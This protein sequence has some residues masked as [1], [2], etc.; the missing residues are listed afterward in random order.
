MTDIRRTAYPR[1]NPHLTTRELEE[2]YQPTQAELHFINVNTKGTPQRL[3]LLLLLKS[4][5]HLGYLPA[6][7]LVPDKIRAYLCQ[8]LELPI[9]TIPEGPERSLQRYRQL[10]RTFLDV[11]PYTQGGQS[12]VASAIRLAAHTMSDPADLINVAMEQL[13]HQRYELPAF[14]LLDRQV[15]HIRHQVHEELYTLVTA[16][17]SE[18]Q[19]QI[20]EQ[21]LAV[22]PEQRLTDFTRFKEAPGTATLKAIRHWEERLAWLDLFPNAQQLLAA[23][24]NT[25]IK[26]FAAQAHALEVSDMHDIQ[27]MSRRHTLLLCL[28]YQAQVQTRDQL[29]L[30]VLKRMRHIHANAKHR[31]RTLQDQ[32]RT[33]TEMMI[34]ALAQIAQQATETAIDAELGHQTRQILSQFGGPE[35]L[36]QHYQLVSAYHDNNYLPLLWSHFR[37]H[38]AVLFRLLSRLELRTTTQEQSLMSA[39][40]FIQHHQ[41]ARKDALPDEISIAFASQRWQTLI[42]TQRNG[43][44]LLQRRALEACVFSYL[45]DGL[46]S[47]DLF[48][49]G[50]EEYADYRTQLLDWHV[51]QQRLDAYCRGLELPNT[52]GAFIQQLR[53]QLTQA[54]Q[55]LDASMPDHAELTLD[56]DGSP[57]LRRGG[58]QSIPPGM[59]EVEALVQ[60]RMPERALLDILKRVQYWVDFTRHFGPPSGADPK[61]KDAISRYLITVF[62]YGCNLGPAQTAR[63]TR[64]LVTLR[65]LKRISD[66]HIST[67]ALEAALRDIINEY[68]RFRLPFFWGAGRAAV[69]DG[70]H[71]ELRKNNLLGEHHIRY[72]SYGGIAYHHISDT[73][74][75][76]F[77]HFI[78]CGV[79]EAVYILDGLLKNE[80]DLQPDTLHADTHGQSEP[81]F[82]LAYLL[83]IQLL[84]RIRQW[85]NLTF[86]RPDKNV[87]YQHIDALFTQ[88]IDWDLIERH[89]P[90]LLQVVLSIQAGTVLPSMLL[91]KLSSYSRQ[92]KLY[93]A[94]REL[95]R[96]VRTLFLV[97]YIS[98]ATLRQG[99]HAATTKIEAYHN[100][101]DWITFG[102]DGVL[103]PR[104]PSEQE[105][106]IKYTD[107]VANAVMLQNVADM[108]DVLHQLAQEGYTIT[109]A[110]VARFSP[111][112]TGNIK[113]F[114]DYVLDM[115]S[116]PDPLQPDKIFWTS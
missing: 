115:D 21:M 77:S 38:R 37:S 109:S 11:K 15:N 3:T 81:V 36:T 54:T 114:G 35:M 53:E 96:V 57:H 92:N 105:K 16:P 91:Q 64:G 103:T 102:S 101:L 39:L 70:T 42:R 62:G 52:A 63:H 22:R 24:T 67:P 23:V 27:S 28:L 44:W 32:Y 95:G 84:P 94:F 85:G 45:A 69:A 98:D 55:R 68:T 34:E 1:F 83:G 10:I 112:L 8:Q 43:Q 4:H 30:M 89:W 59:E 90:D 33:S 107:L 48:V 12:V 110:I 86:Y 46:R 20:L 9:D 7:A 76:L 108:T 47:G 41:N 18:E 97:D 60:E 25:K 26:Q 19:R 111:Y 65:T 58:Q 72:G 6:L 88:T 75:A 113:R 99:I 2:I 61:L 116:I 31:L 74:I 17:L 14:S 49:V 87:T 13:I 80:S 78:A 51:C 93:L 56:P 104:D 82:G 5:Q 29:V 66:Q 40:F 100:F 71:I 106:R 50:S 73:Y 79:W